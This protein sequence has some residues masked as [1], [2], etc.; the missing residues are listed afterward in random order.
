M[1]DLNLCWGKIFLFHLD[2]L[3]N[4]KIFRNVIFSSNPHFIFVFFVQLEISAKLSIVIVDNFKQVLYY[5]SYCLQQLYFHPPLKHC[6]K[7]TCTRY[8]S[9]VFMTDNSADGGT[10]V[11]CPEGIICNGVNYNTVIIIIIINIII[12]IIFVVVSNILTDMIL[13]QSFTQAHVSDK[14]VNLPK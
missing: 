3:R 1:V 7:L 10:T 4:Q 8:L 9:E 5:Q 13:V 12:L 6:V 11:A 14:Y 2:Y